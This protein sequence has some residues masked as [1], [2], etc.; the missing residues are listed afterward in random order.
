MFVLIE[1]ENLHI[2][3][4]QDIVFEEDI[5]LAGFNPLTNVLQKIKSPDALASE[6]GMQFKKR[7]QII[8]NFQDLY[9]QNQNLL[10]IRQEVHFVNEDLNMDIKQVLDELQHTKCQ[11]PKQTIGFWKN[12]D[13]N[14]LLDEELE[15][16]ELRCNLE[17]LD[18]NAGTKSP[19]R[20][21]ASGSKADLV[22]LNAISKNEQISQLT[23][24]KKELEVK[25]KT[26][27]MYN[28]KLEVSFQN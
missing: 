27:K 14:I 16:D 6:E 23:K 11:S 20:N 25:N 19:A 12:S 17:N 3:S 5:F 9:Q 18:V 1:N 15:V 22:K 28:D 21:S 8:K 13:V 26:K 10:N 2:P 24:L 4:D 7:L